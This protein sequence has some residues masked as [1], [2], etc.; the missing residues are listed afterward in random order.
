VGERRLSSVLRLAGEAIGVGWEFGFE[1]LEALAWVAQ[2]VEASVYVEH[3]L[4]RTATGFRFALANPPLR[5]GG[6][7]SARLSVNGAAIAPERVRVRVL[8]VGP[9]RVTSTL[10][11]EQPLDL[12][13]GSRTEFDVEA[14]V[15]LA[16]VSLTVRLELQNVAVPPLVWL[17]FQ[18]ALQEPPSP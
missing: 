3:S 13:C 9:W 4:R 14:S 8:P 5:V 17:E 6:F 1:S 15:P 10:G 18:E 16:T 11:A 12:Q 2:T 7:S